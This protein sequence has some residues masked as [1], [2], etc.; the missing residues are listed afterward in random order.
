MKNVKGITRDAASGA[1]TAAPEGPG[2]TI[3]VVAKRTGLTMETLRAWERRYGF[4]TPERRPGSNRRLYSRA[5]VEKLLA[6]C[7]VLVHGYRVGD[8]IGKSTSELRAL[9]AADSEREGGLEPATTSESRATPERLVDLLEREEIAEI[10]EQLRQAAV[11]LGPRRF[12]TEIAHPFAVQVGAAWADGRLSVRHEHVATECLVTRLRALLA[13]YQDVTGRPVV[14]LA[15]LP[16]EPHGLALQMVALYLVAAGAKP[17]LLGV[18]TPPED[19]LEAARAFGVDVVGL[20]MTPVT[21]AQES[22]RQIKYLRKRLDEKVPL[23]LGGSGVHATEPF[24]GNVRT[25]TTWPELDEALHAWL[26][27]KGLKP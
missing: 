16:G 17:R 24:E 25:V 23:W 1:P 18:S 27:T 13:T 4:P 15:T 5:D 7:G 12:V 2:D 10:E 8:V 3:L 19:I 11:A 14:L 21:D 9:V 20:T 6:V 26:R 22:K